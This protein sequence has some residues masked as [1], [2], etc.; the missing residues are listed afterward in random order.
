MLDDV[1]VNEI[2]LRLFGNL[3]FFKCSS[4]C[5]ALKEENVGSMK[6]RRLYQLLRA[7]NDRSVD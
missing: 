6:P 3:I 5:L 4:V 1:L 7:L 2:I